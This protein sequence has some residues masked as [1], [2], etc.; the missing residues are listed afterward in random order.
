MWISVG[1]FGVG[2]NFWPRATE[3]ANNIYIYNDRHTTVKRRRVTKRNSCRANFEKHPVGLNF[4]EVL[5]ERGWYDGDTRWRQV[6]F[7]CSACWLVLALQH[8]QIHTFCMFV[9]VYMCFVLWV[10]SNI[11]KRSE[12][13]LIVY[14]HV[15]F[16]ELS[17]EKQ[18]W[19]VRF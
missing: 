6:E 3:R 12:V 10:C 13:A 7:S 16:L 11:V 19:I 17:K 18:G 5:T 2:Y 1:G 4:N 14:E 15:F 9:S 8:R